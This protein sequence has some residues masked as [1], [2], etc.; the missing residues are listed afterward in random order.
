ML[1][2][3][4]LKPGD[5]V[6]IAAT[7]RKVTEHEMSYAVALLRSW[8]LEVIIPHELYDSENQF[9]GSD[10]TRT[11]VLQKLLDSE[12][13]KAIFCAR[14]GYGTVRIIDQL[15]FRKFVQVPKWV[16]GFSDITALHA[17]IHNCLGICSMH[18]PM[19]INC[20]PDK[21]DSE[22]MHYLHNTLFGGAEAILSK[23]NAL[24][25][26]GA[27]EGELIG[28]NLS[29]LYSLVGSRSMPDCR[30]KILFLEDLDEYLYHIDRMLVNLKRNGILSHLRGL[31]VGGMS[32]MK[33][34]TIPFG[35]T[36]EEIIAE[37]THE[38]DYPVCYGF[39]AG[40]EKRNLALIMGAAYTL[41]VA[42]NMSTLKLVS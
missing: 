30:D 27:A 41:D 6:A 9:A 8:K 21:L 38:F 15:D 10:Y 18:A 24:N 17:H 37:H 2:P 28:G 22:S 13:I 26:E 35:K 25:R 40:H 1:Q 33:D 4:Y 14:G 23:A 3:P 12:E 29:V 20:L 5:K 16:I 34:N 7:A 31:V 42:K 19:P 32:D 36:A 11:R 39:P